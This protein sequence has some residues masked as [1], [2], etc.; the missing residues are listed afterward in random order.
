MCART[1][2]SRVENVIGFRDPHVW[3]S[4][5]SEAVV[6]LHVIVNDRAIHQEVL[7]RARKI[8]SDV[9]SDVTVQVE[10]ESFLDK[11]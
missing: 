4:S 9:G 10:P 6:T 2:I 1:Q 5:G 7:K 11:H 3:I 8:L